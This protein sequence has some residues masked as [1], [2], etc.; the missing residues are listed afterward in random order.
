[1]ETV[2]K[3][4]S[5]NKTLYIPLYGKAYVSSQGI[6][7]SD[8][9]A[10]AIWETEGFPL[11]GKA[12][13]KWLA[14]YM[15]M[16]AAVF[17]RWISEQSKRSPGAVV[18]HLGCG[19]DS[20]IRRVNGTAAWYDVDFPEVI[21]VRRRFYEET[22]SYHM[23]G[24]DLR[25]EQWLLRIPEGGHALVVMEGVS[26]YL[27]PEQLQRLLARLTARFDRVRLLMDCYTTAAAKAS[28]YKNPINQVG[29]TQVWGLDDP[30]MAAEGTGLRFLRE[31]EMTPA[32]LTGQLKGM[33]QRIFRRVYAGKMAKKLY[34]MYEFETDSDENRTNGK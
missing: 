25:Q 16:R 11:K 12:A 18:L 5:V 13:S 3:M 2:M 15:A 20:R 29:V 26:M 33:E 17:D 23:I 32:E 22:G 4:D 30:D 8:P 27:E 7:L 21:D 31:W 9:M 10:E 14:Y 34:R 24:G 28:R 6:L 1:M 19:L